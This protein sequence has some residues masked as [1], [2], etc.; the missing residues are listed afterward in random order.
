MEAVNRVVAE[1]L[2]HDPSHVW[3]F[4]EEVR[5][6]HFLTAGRTGAELKLLLRPAKA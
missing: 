3:V 5:D 4:F 6:E 2:G 1:N